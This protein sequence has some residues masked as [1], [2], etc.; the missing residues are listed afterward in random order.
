MAR[1]HATTN[2][3]TYQQAAARQAAVRTNAMAIWSLVLAI[4]SIGGIGSLAGIAL[5]VRAHRRISETGERGRG[6]AIAAVILGVVTLL[7]SIAYWAYLGTHFNV[8]PGHGG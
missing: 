1:P 8:S 4:V 2:G 7:L 5:G 3:S 6:L